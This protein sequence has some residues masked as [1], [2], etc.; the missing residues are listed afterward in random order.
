MANTCSRRAD[1]AADR[2]EI[3]SYTTIT[4][5]PS[6]LGEFGQ[7]V[8]GSGVDYVNAVGNI[9]LGVTQSVGQTKVAVT[10]TKAQ[11][12]VAITE[13]VES[14][15]KLDIQTTGL[16]EQARIAADQAKSKYRTIPVVILTSGAA[17]IG[18]IAIGAW[19]YNKV[20]GDYEI[21]Y[22]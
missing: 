17:I 13:A 4:S 6:R 8:P 18:A 12:A 22:E 21:E 11:R 19:A 5:Q 7:L 2:E 14:T 15:K 1:Y 3:V 20:V 10:Q 16:T 9:I